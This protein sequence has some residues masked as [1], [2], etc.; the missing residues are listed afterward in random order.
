MVVF[1]V[2]PWINHFAL[3]FQ[4]VLHWLWVVKPFWKHSWQTIFYYLTLW[5]LSELSTIDTSIILT[6][7]FLFIFLLDKMT[8]KINTGSGA[9]SAQFNK[10]WITSFPE[11]LLLRWEFQICCK[12]SCFHS[13][14]ECIKQG[15][16]SLSGQPVP[17]LYHSHSKELTLVIQS[18]S[19]L[20][21]L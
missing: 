5:Y 12:E 14:K 16:H 21:Q 20:L 9:I 18:K 15:M 13:W 19:S 10:T 7:H 2:Q 17:E 8:L 3:P 4:H 6:I 11:Q 1:I